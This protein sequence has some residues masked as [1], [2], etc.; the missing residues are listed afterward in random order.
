MPQGSLRS[1]GCSRF[2]YNELKL[3]VPKNPLFLSEKVATGAREIR[4]TI[5]EVVYV[6][7]TCIDIVTILTSSQVFSSSLPS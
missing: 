3:K 4:D 2:T 6:M 1:G 5:G 7:D